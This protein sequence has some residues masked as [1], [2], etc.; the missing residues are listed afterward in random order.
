MSLVLALVAGYAIVIVLIA[1]AFVP[2]ATVNDSFGCPVVSPPTT[3]A[4]RSS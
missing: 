4:R 3:H 2:E 1:R